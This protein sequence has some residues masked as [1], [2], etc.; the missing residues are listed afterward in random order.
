M[1]TDTR[2]TETDEYTPADLAADVRILLGDPASMAAAEAVLSRLRASLTDISPVTV[3]FLAVQR[4]PG[5]VVDAIAVLDEEF[6]EVFAEMAFI[7]GRVKEVEAAERARLAPLLTEA[8]QL[9]LE[10]TAR[11][12][13][14]PAELAYVATI[15]EAA[16]AKYEAAGLSAVEIDGLTQKI[17]ADNAQ[18]AADLRDEQARL[19][20]EVET[21]GE[22]LRTRDESALPEDFAPRPPVVGITYRPVVAQ[23][24]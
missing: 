7:A 12:A 19:A 10:G 23:R 8:A 16:R 17:A 22:F 2:T 11:L 9:V 20:D 15:P 24:G 6:V 21:L 1:T 5:R 3:A 14:I 18:R 13:N 4:H